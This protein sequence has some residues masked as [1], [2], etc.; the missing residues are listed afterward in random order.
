MTVLNDLDIIKKFGRH[1]SVG[2]TLTFDNN[3]DSMKWEPGA[4]LPLDRL[5]TLKTLHEEGVHTWASFEPVINTIQSLYLIKWSIPY[6]DHYKIGKIN[7]YQGMDK[8]IDWTVF[9]NRVVSILRK[10]KPF[11]VKYDLRQAAPTVPLYG[12]EVLPDEFEPDIFE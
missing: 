8:N 3:K 1:I 4:S 11:Y 2:M 6:I 10:N 12:N 5:S 9:L 7:N